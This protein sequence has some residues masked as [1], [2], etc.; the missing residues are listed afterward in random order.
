M[1]GYNH[2]ALPTISAEASMHCAYCTAPSKTFNLAGMHLSN[3]FI[4]NP[5]VRGKLMMGKVM[6]MSMAQVAVSYEACRLAYDKAGPWLDALIDVVDG[7]AKYVE[8]FLAEHIPEAKVYPL[9]GTYLLWVDFRGLGMTHKELEKM[10]LAADLYLDE[11][12]MFGR[13]GRGFERFNLA[14]PRSAVE[15]AM[16]RLLAG[17]N[18]VKADWEANGK[19][20]HI[21]L[22]AGMQMPDF[23]YNTPFARDLSFKTETAGKPTVLLFHR[24]YSCGL[25]SMALHQLKASYDVLTNAG[26]QA[27]VVM[28]S[29]PESIYE[30]LKG[31]NPFPFDIICDPDRKLYERLN[32]FSADFIFDLAGDNFQAMIPMLGQAMSGGG[33]N[34]QPTEG[35][36]NQLPAW[37]AIDAEGKIL[38][39]H[40]GN[41]LFDVPEAEEMVSKF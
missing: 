14:M 2:V 39:A 33:G 28:Q 36:K 24:Y 23:T 8:A 4:E 10:N 34:Q 3:I 25:C 20:E 26:V 30:D 27:K 17:W 21:T 16:K 9:E 5:E 18:A 6:T 31:E 22:E 12:P 37:F 1:P 35:E 11:G 13:S 7:N 15:A 38:Y 19:P 32:V 41:S 40:Y 29:T